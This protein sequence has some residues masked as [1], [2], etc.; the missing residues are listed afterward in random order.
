MKELTV[1][2]FS[3]ND[4]LIAREGGN[5]DSYNVEIGA[6]TNNG[7]TE[8]EIVIPAMEIDTKTINPSVMEAL[9]GNYRN[10]MTRSALDRKA[11]IV[12][13]DDSDLN[14]KAEMVKDDDRNL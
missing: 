10:R 4:R 2:K 3:A 14:R 13:K 6:Y 8:G 12:E 1:I 5:K 7:I 11:K 9:Q